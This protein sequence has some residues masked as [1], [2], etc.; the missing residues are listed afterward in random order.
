M[1]GQGPE[2]G[3]EREGGGRKG[4]ARGKDGCNVTF[5]FD[6]TGEMREGGRRER[7]QAEDGGLCTTAPPRRWGPKG[8]LGAIMFGRFVR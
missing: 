2:G 8:Y 5:A 3:G 7:G 6:A 4:K 1:A